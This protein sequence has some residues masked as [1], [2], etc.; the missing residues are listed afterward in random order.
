MRRQM[1]IQGGGSRW[2]L[3][4]TVLERMILCRG[5]APAIW[6]LLQNRVTYHRVKLHKAVQRRLENCKGNYSQ[7]QRGLG[8]I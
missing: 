4:S 8:N 6:R 3:Q 2:E 7:S 1:G 5:K